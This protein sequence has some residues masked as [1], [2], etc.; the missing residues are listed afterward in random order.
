MNKS[1]VTVLGLFAILSLTASAS[2]FA[3]EIRCAADL[4]SPLQNDIYQ[5]NLSF[6]SS[7]QG[8]A[9]IYRNNEAGIV[10][11]Q[12]AATV[13]GNEF[14]WFETEE[15][16]DEKGKPVFESLT[17]VKSHDE[18]T[19][20]SLWAVRKTRAKPS[21]RRRVDGKSSIVRETHIECTDTQE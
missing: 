19:N 14:S 20:Q 16:T 21:E 18:K 5:I 17:L 2:S 13:T 1:A 8:R 11:E 12:T 4:H 9:T 10:V 15:T 3:R 7:D 6:E